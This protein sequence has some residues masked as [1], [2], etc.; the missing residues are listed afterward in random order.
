MWYVVGLMCG[1]T[2]EMLQDITGIHFE[3]T[4]NNTPNELGI[5]WTKMYWPHSH[6]IYK[7]PN[8]TQT[9]FIFCDGRSLRRTRFW[10]C[11]LVF[12]FIPRYY[13]KRLLVVQDPMIS[14][15]QSLAL[16]SHTTESRVGQ[17]Q[18]MCR[19]C[20]RSSCVLFTNGTTKHLSKRCPHV[21]PHRE[22]RKSRFA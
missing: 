4:D 19:F 1:V 18:Q 22:I 12:A 2:H 14:E 15:Q 8:L 16:H 13:F 5:C 17:Q 20:K 9:G 10:A 3:T 6:V 7:L 11:L 21:S